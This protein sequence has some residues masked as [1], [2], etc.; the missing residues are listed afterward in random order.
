MRKVADNVGGPLTASQSEKRMMRPAHGAHVR[1][2]RARTQEPR[3]KVHG[4]VS[5]ELVDRQ[6]V[7]GHRDVDRRH[8]HKHVEAAEGFRGGIDGAHT[9]EASVRSA[10][11]IDA[12]RP[13]AVISSADRSAS[14]LDRL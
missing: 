2:R 6:L 10:S 14:S 1:D 9:G 12:R 4:E 5:I 3:L 11:T 7:E 8:V 13:A